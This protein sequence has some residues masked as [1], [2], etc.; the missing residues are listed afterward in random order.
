MTVAV[1]L[2]AECGKIFAT[3]KK[4][5]KLTKRG[6]TRKQHQEMIHTRNDN[7]RKYKK[8]RR[9][10]RKERRKE[11]RTRK[12]RNQTRSKEKGIK[13]GIKKRKRNSITKHL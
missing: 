4:L 10:R 12:T 13:K 11:N 7:Q 6:H 8:K 3:E 1:L 9:P 2:C 5:R